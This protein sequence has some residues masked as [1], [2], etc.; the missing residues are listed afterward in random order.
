MM[1]Y[2]AG[3]MAGIPD[4]N[5]TEFAK[6]ADQL[7][8]AGYAVFNP[9]ASNLES[10]PIEDIFAYDLE[11]LCRQADAIAMIPG[12]EE[13]EGAFAEHAVAK[14]LKKQIIYL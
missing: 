2:L 9:A 10:W 5:K 12:W 3:R 6:Y 7:R 8:L 14:R 11:F 1:V 4:H 13:S